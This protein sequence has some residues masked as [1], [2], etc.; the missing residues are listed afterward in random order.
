MNNRGSV[1]CLTLALVLV[2]L[3]LGLASIHN[4]GGQNLDA[5]RRQ[6]SLEA[7][8]L[9]DAGVEVARSK[10]ALATPD[11]IQPNA[12]CREDETHSLYPECGDPESFNVMQDGN[13]HVFSEQD[14]DCPTCIDRWH[15]RSW[16]A[17]DIYNAAGTLDSQLRGIDAIAA[18]Y[19]I[20][21]AITT[22]GTVNGSC[23][24]WGT[25][26]IGGTCADHVDF[27]FEDIFNG[28]S[29]A[30]FI[31]MANANGTE[32]H[33]TSVSQAFNINN[34][35]VLFMEG[36]TMNKVT[37]NTDDPA[38]DFPALLIVDGTGY[39]GVPTAQLQIQGTLPFCGIIWLVGEMKLEGNP[40]IN[41]TI[42]V[43]GN[44]LGDMAF[45]GTS[46]VNFSPLCIE[47]A[48][49]ASITT[50]APALIAWKE[51]AL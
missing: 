11:L 15:I 31:S 26:T 5:E 43:D 3:L 45:G 25:A 42:F 37:I 21:N 27:T 48:L 2:F 7:F 33:L 38:Y 10:L 34:V 13:Y 40:V 32:Y 44:P 16:G 24:P 35:T 36:N 51:Y 47:G 50:G 28:T 14:P 18:R 1:L 4:A 39:T 8:W 46:A 49:P 12:A 19:D 23:V 30:D 29:Y 20:S 22:H 6:A 41:G 9:A 17:A